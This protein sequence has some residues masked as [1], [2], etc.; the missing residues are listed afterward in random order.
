M[1]P[2]MPADPPSST[3]SR[4]HRLFGLFRQLAE[5]GTL[6]APL[7]QVDRLVDA[8]QPAFLIKHDVHGVAPEA[9]LAFAKAEMELGVVGAYFF[10][11]PDHPL[12]GGVYSF[13]EQA[14]VMSGVRAM[15]HEIGLHIDPYFLMDRMG[16]P[17]RDVLGEILGQFEDVGLRLTCGNMHGNSRFKMPDVNG[18]G[19]SF[20]LFA[21]VGRQQDYPELRDVPAETARLIRDNRV[22]L[23]DFGFTHWADMPLWSARHGFVVTNF[24][25]DNQLGKRGT[26]EIVTHAD[27]NRRYKLADHQPPGSRTPSTARR[28]VECPPPGA[29]GE[30]KAGGAF[31]AGSFVLD[32]DSDEVVE[33]FDRLSD[34]PAL[35][36]VHPEH[37][38]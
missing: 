9:L 17:L 6:F 24:V 31:P 18:Y 11:A 2:P 20:D 8:G 12:T 7:S 28:I 27:T 23:R 15:G 36:L 14:A 37:Y 32:F 34:H 10:M 4:R 26:I 5:S 1:M 38:V 21:E 16:K 25:T 13:A 3:T 19:T 33:W 22:S 29:G 30:E 35:L